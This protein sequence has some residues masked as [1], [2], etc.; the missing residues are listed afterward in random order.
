[1]MWGACTLKELKGAV[2]S[3]IEAVGE[4]APIGSLIKCEGEDYIDDY[5]SFFWACIDQDGK[6]V[7]D[8]GGDYE[9]RLQPGEVSA[10]GVY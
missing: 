2:E 6:V 5:V 8:E 4:D 10:I 9:T 7:G 1:M 3:M